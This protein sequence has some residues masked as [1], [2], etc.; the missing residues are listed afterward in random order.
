MKILHAF[1][2][3]KWTGPAEPAVRLAAALQPLAEV[4]FACG[5]CPHADLANLVQNAAK[6]AGLAVIDGLRLRKHFDP[7]HGARDYRRLRDLLSERRYDVVHAHLMNDHLLLGAAARS[8]TSRPRIVRTVYGGPDLSPVIRTA[9]AFSRLT[10]GVLA[11]SESAAAEVRR[12]TDLPAERLAVVPGAVDIER[13]AIPRLAPL[14]ES[15]R[16]EFGFAADDVVFGIVARVQRHRRYDLL[17]E[18]FARVVA[19]CP[20]A[21]LVV[22]GRGTHIE[23]VAEQPIARLRLERSVRLAGY[24]EGESYVSALAGLDAAIFLVPGSDGSCRAARELLAAGLP[25]VVTPRGPLPEIVGDGECG[26]VANEE[27]EEFAT[28]LI[29]IATEHDRRRA[30]SI[31]ARSRAERLYSIAGQA[32]LVLDFYTRM[33]EAGPWRRGS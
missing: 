8:S 27:V 14:R 5:A 31:A 19:E 22:I 29:A 30:L 13:F 28:A 4:E 15:L 10:D 17:F 12:R 2:N 21:K 24:R 25:L 9:L 3:W 7:W 33:K 1:S 23:E 16:A 11:A 20:R 26:I 6:A 18:A 32:R